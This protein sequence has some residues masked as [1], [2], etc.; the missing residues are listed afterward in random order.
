MTISAKAVFHIGPVYTYMVKYKV[1]T[2][3]KILMKYI[4]WISNDITF[5]KKINFN[6]AKNLGS[7]TFTSRSFVVEGRYY[8]KY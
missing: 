2:K 1:T 5:Y 3:C 7:A 6:S 4:T 8:E